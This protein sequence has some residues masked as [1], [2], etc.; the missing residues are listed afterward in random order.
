[1]GNAYVEGPEY[2]TIALFGGNCELKTIEEVAY[3]NY[4]CDQLGH[5]H[6][7]SRGGDLLDHRVLSKKGM[8]GE[9]EIGRPVRN[10][11]ILK[12]RG[13]PAGENCRP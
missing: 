3:A 12:T 4:L 1:L 9:K 2:E 5:R 10:S 8:L 13:L 11:Q 7:F 6:H